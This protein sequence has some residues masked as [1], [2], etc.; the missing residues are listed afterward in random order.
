MTSDF[1]PDG[2]ERAFAA[3]LGR[4][5]TT[6]EA[7][8]EKWPYFA[9]PDTGEWTTTDDGDWCDGHW[10]EMLRITGEVT[11]DESL[12]REAL[13]RTE[14]S[15]WKL[16]KD[17]QFRGHRFYYS[18]ARLYEY[19]GDQSMRT[20]ALAAAYAM[21]SMA[22]PVN[23]A[24]P[25][26]T[27]VQ[28]RNVTI[29]SRSIVA[30]DNLHPNC[31][32]DWWAWR[33]TGDEIFRVGPRRM[34][35]VLEKYY[36]REDGSTKDF[37]EFDPVTGAVLRE[38]TLFGTVENSC[39]SRGQAWVIAGALLGY[40]T[41]RDRYYL[42]LATTAFDY[43]WRQCGAEPP[44]YDFADPAEGIPVDTS[45]AAI[46]TAALARLAT[47]PD[48]PGQA[49]PLLARLKP[50]LEA[51]I[52][53]TTPTSADD[54]RPQGMLLDGCFNMPRKVGDR[55]ETLWGDLYLLDTLYTLRRG[56]PFA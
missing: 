25:I 15:R 32:L 3:L 7:V 56:S 6:R 46:V 37:I 39:W 10:I 55:H 23:G 52:A 27:Q 2:A 38:F 41:F 16:E 30:V 36:L 43:W 34:A 47:S 13:A 20:L 29:A 54:S 28:V 31:R 51:L 40:E 42:D 26:G 35:E 45:A 5:R 49:A 8:G 14:R 50:M 18:A 19:T 44:P 22:M 9:E 33:E 1:L 21:R 17:D 12:V 11:G 24:M 48:G 53:R 4:V